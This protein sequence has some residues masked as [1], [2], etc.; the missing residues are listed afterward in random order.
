M[1]AE[2][3]GQVLKRMP[4]SHIRSGTR[5]GSG[6]QSEELNS[7]ELFAGGGGMALGMK[8][9]GFRHLALVEW[10]KP[11]ATVLIHNASTTTWD[12]DRVL[13]NDVRVVL[14]DLVSLA[15]VTLIAGGPP[16]QPFSLAGAGA[17]HSDERNMFPA[18]LELVRRML[19]PYV[20]FENVP[21]LLRASFA[22]YLQYV[23]DQMRR[24]DVA[25][26]SADELWSDH[27]SRIT[28][29]R[30]SDIYHVYRE[31]IDAA[32][33]GVAQNRKRV[34]LVGIRADLADKSAWPGIPRTH[35]RVSL[36]R[37]QW[38]T[39]EY[40]AR[41]GL[42]APQ[43]VPEYAS[44]IVR[45]IRDGAE[46]SDLAPWKT[47]RDLLATIPEP[48]A[49]G[50]PPG[51]PNHQRIPGARVYRSH[52]GSPL[53]LPS[54]T[55]KAGVHG[56]AGGEAMIRDLDGGVRYLT[57][58]EAAM[59]QG[60]PRDYEFPTSRSRMMGVIGNA[61]AVDVAAAIGSALVSTGGP[62]C[63]GSRSG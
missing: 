9:A 26:R 8:R 12:R 29:S 34:F 7:I 32:D 46:T 30:G 33:L 43:S 47:L 14:S 2:A 24:P 5:L 60:F 54:K 42:T 52:T 56:V 48:L 4:R 6:D 28:A 27:H 39:G 25:P 55:I 18:A 38:V 36:F 19:P 22:P 49:E 17:G 23:Q 51:W 31:Q 40:W 44:P 11:A 50:S 61:V 15:P 10:W 21:G 63:W 1:Y 59:A 62:D 45:R 57:V 16:C 3:E 41:H 20:V 53:D 58:R 35:S 37:D 13:E